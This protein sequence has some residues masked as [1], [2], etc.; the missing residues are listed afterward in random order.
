MVELELSIAGAGHIEGVDAIELPVD[1]FIVHL[2]GSYHRLQIGGWQDCI[3]QC[4]LASSY[5]VVVESQ[6]KLF[7]ID[8]G[9]ITDGCYRVVLIGGKRVVDLTGERCN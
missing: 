2:E 5:I 8:K 1:I 3:A 4:R 6:G 9:C 7:A